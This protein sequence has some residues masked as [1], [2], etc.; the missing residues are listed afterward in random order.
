MALLLRKHVLEDLLPYVCTFP[1]C[2]LSGHPFDTR[3]AW[4]M[5]EMQNHR[6]EYFCNSHSHQAYAN[7]GEFQVHMQNIHDMSHDQTTALVDLFKQP[8]ISKEPRCN[9]CGKP[10]M[11]LKAHISRHLQDLALFAIP[12]SD[13]I[14]DDGDERI[15]NETDRAQ[16][17]S[18][19][20]TKSE[21][22]T[23]PRREVVHSCYLITQQH[24]LL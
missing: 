2:S 23:G 16:H 15:E 6:I 5:H 22:R 12:R 10:S 20:T 11:G 18:S 21:V 7:F 8:S 3:T 13:Y 4:W 1:N 19:D 17:I 9:L 14:T 24:P